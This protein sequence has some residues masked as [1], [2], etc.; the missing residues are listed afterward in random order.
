MVKI[1]TDKKRFT[2]SLCSVFSISYPFSLSIPPLLPSFAI[3]FFD[4]HF[5]FCIYVFSYFLSGYLGIAV[6]LLNLQQSQINLFSIQNSAS[7]HFI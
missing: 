4:S 1:V 7:Q 6:N 3:F 2:L 5:L